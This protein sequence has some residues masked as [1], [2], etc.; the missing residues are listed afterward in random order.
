MA[1]KQVEIGKLPKSG[2]LDKNHLSAEDAIRLEIDLM[3][4]LDDVNI[5]Q[6]IDSTITKEN[7]LIFMEYVPGGSVAG[8]LNKS[9]P[10]PERL[11]QNISFQL[12]NGLDYLHSLY[13]LILTTSG[14]I[15]RDIKA[16]NG[17]CSLTFQCL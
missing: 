6:Y 1:V 5:V 12:L 9:G 8:I 16:A 2:R 11:C 3:K 4:E 10:F 13:L 14:I 7:I 15:H 17:T